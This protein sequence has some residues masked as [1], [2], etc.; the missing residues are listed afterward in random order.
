MAL[1]TSLDKHLEKLKDP[2]RDLRKRYPLKTLVI[3]TVM[4]GI[5]G[6]DD[7]VAVER[8]CHLKWKWLSTL[9]DLPLSI[10]AH[11][12]F[13][14]VFALLDQEAFR[15]CFR[16]WTQGLLDAGLIRLKQGE[17]IA[18]DGKTS[19]RTHDRAQ[20]RSALQ[21]VTAWASD[22]GLVLA[23]EHVERDGLEDGSEITT[24]PKLLETLML[25]GCIV[26]VDAANCQ[27]KNARIITERGGDYVFAL[28]E[29]QPR[30]Y[31]EVARTVEEALRTRFRGIQHETLVTHNKGHG[32]LEKRRHI[33]ITDP[34][35][36]EYFNR[37]GRWWNLGAIGI[38]ERTRTIGDRATTEIH[39]FI[40]SLKTNVQRFAHTVRQHWGIENSLHW[41]LDVTFH[42]D[43]NRARV[44]A[45]AEN[46]SVLRHFA[47][48]LIKLETSTKDSLRGKRQRAS[49]SDEYVLQILLACATS[50][51]S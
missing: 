21:T 12:T 46:L 35:E 39:F 10:P 25:K 43:L 9:M 29:N 41:V 22:T 18:I 24:L 44:A 51:A 3:L 26:T 48:N 27:T 31:G 13:R 37:D 14:R 17:V 4:A 8:Y 32:R 20:H 50:P 2:R 15:Q 23:Q 30:F 42:D 7:W 47:I 1:H 36:I 28:K 45:Q 19:R 6:A 5:S 34:A 16:E 33:L 49:W 11:D 38:V 40:T